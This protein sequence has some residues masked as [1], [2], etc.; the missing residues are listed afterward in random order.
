M[1]AHLEQPSTPSRLAREGY[2]PGECSLPLLAPIQSLAVAGLGW[3]C[4]AANQGSP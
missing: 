2:H 4:A 3:L 1:R